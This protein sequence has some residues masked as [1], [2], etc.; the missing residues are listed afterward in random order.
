LEEYP[1]FLL[2]EVQI[3]RSCEPEYRGLAPIHF[4]FCSNS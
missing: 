1:L 3:G 2:G 4:P